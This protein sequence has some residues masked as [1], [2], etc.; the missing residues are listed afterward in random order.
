M[1]KWKTNQQPSIHCF[2]SQYLGTQ[3]VV[4]FLE[5]N[6]LTCKDSRSQEFFW[7]MCLFPNGNNLVFFLPNYVLIIKYQ[8]LGCL[9]CAVSSM[10][11]SWFQFKSWSQ[12]PGM[13]P[14]LGLPTRWGVSLSPSPFALPILSRP[15]SNSYM[16]SLSKI[17]K[18]TKKYNKIPKIHRKI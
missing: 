9:G 5:S 13:E 14:C 2:L 16:G 1:Q 17:N 12:G 4:S 11:S 10:S 15:R 6:V 8:T 18:S 3:M 7:R